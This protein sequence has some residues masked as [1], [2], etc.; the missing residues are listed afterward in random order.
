MND[1]TNLVLGRLSL[2][3]P[4]HPLL[5]IDD[6]F[7]QLRFERG[8]RTFRNGVCGHYK[9]LVMPFKLANALAAFIM[10]LMNRVFKEQLDKFVMVFIDDIMKIVDY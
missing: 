4:K 2:V 3:T 5:R 8:S 7:N 10:D 1:L 9:F 6:L